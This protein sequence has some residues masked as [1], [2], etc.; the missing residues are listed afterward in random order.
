MIFL[1]TQ[2]LVS[3]GRLRGGADAPGLAAHVAF[4]KT[5]RQMPF[6]R[7]S[8]N[9]AFCFLFSLAMPDPLH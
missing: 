5:Q 7:P 8:A 2:L 9:P 3:G 4:I 6:V 1:A